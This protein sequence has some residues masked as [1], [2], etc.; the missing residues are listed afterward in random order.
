MPQPAAGEAVVRLRRAAVS[1]FDVQTARGLTGFRGVMGHEFVAVVESVHGDAAASRRLVDQRVVGS[2]IHACGG[3]D[4]C[5]RG[6]SQHCRDRTIMGMVGRGGCLVERFCVPVKNLIALPGHVD[7]DR[8]VF[9]VNLA[10]ALHAAQQ[11]TVTNRPYVTVLGDGPLALITAQ[12]MVKMNASVRVVGRQAARLAVCERWGIKHRAVDEVG[13]RGDQ[14]V[15]IDCTGWGD[16]LAISLG[17]VR[18]RGKIVLKTL[19]PAGP[20]ADE[21]LAGAMAAVVLHEIE[22]IGSFLGPMHE[23]VNALAENRVD[24]LSLI[25]RRFALSDGIAALR[26]ASASDAMKVIV[27][28]E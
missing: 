11:V 13:L 18:P 26:A 20:N 21:P 22:L 2:I 6:L 10:G 1:A 5:R 27:S 28:A 23:A 15:V 4:L 3:C 25:S 9:A 24:V 8:A 17:M 12:I 16:G 7:D 14:D 19:W